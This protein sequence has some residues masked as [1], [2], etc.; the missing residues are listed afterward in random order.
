MILLWAWYAE[1]TFAGGKA[2]G[3]CNVAVET[4]RS[5]PLEV[6]GIGGAP[7]RHS[8]E[9]L[10]NVCKRLFGWS[11]NSGRVYQKNIVSHKLL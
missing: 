11:H 1:D 6:W 4:V 2:G 3:P 10:R 7:I 8:L 5:F 9:S